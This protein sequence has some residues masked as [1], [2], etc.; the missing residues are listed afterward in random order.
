MS[1]RRQFL[2]TCSVLTLSAGLAPAARWTS[3]SPVREAALDQLTFTGFSAQVG[4]LFRLAHGAGPA[5]LKLVEAKTLPSHPPA[6]DAGNEKFSLLFTGSKDRSLAQNTH[7]FEHAELGTFEMFIVPI[8][9]QD[10]SRIY[11]EAVFN[12]PVRETLT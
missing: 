3:P 11:Y 6:E 9:H 8:G 2:W 4:T 12:R 5:S 1:N 10:S 7:R